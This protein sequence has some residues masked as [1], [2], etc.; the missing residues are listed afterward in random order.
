MAAA[1]NPK[2]ARAEQTRATYTVASPLEHDGDLYAPGDP[3][4]L[5]EAEAAPLLAGGVVTAA[6]AAA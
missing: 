6:A 5:T 2:A 4:E 1:R 3:V